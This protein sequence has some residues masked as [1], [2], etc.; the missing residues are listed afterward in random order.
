[1]LR[2]GFL[3]T[4]YAWREVAP[5]PIDAVLRVLVVDL[6]GFGHSDKPTGTDGYDARAMAEQVWSL[7]AQTARRPAGTC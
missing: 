3:G 1:V 7:A 5:G 6:P 4:G 2:H